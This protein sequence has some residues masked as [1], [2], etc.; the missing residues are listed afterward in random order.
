[1]LV[2]VNVVKVDKIKVRLIELD[3]SLFINKS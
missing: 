3:I 2:C 1:M